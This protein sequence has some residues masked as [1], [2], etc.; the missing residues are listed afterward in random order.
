MPATTLAT[1]WAELVSVVPA[2]QSYWSASRENQDLSGCDRDGYPGGRPMS[3]HDRYA[4][5]TR[6]VSTVT[7][8]KLVLIASRLRCHVCACLDLRW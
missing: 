2:G 3:W 8:L 4:P 6:T 7:S 5:R 1:T